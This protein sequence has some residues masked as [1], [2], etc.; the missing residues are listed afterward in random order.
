MFI[1][2][3]GLDYLGNMMI[4]VGNDFYQLDPGGSIQL[5]QDYNKH[6]YQFNNHFVKESSWII[7]TWMGIALTEGTHKETVSCTGKW[8]EQTPE[9]KAWNENL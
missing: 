1:G 4:K 6:G 9:S 2:S 7:P 3:I 8:S 5:R